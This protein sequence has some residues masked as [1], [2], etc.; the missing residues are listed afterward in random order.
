M[1]ET[2]G[3]PHDER[4]HSHSSPS[5]ATGKDLLSR[6]RVSCR[7][8]RA[9]VIGNV[10][11]P[12][13]VSQEVGGHRR[14][15]SAGPRCPPPSGSFLLR[16]CDSCSS[17]QNLSRRHIEGRQRGPARRQ[18][19]GKAREGL[20]WASVLFSSSCSWSSASG[21]SICL[22]WSNGERTLRLSEARRSRVVKESCARRPVIWLFGVWSQRTPIGAYSSDWITLKE[23]HARRLKNAVR[24]AQPFLRFSKIGV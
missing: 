6:S 22:S 19:C 18:A 15:T 1:E 3:E 8:R 13:N 17:E 7:S 24:R 23:L 12:T 16:V 10:D 20:A 9:H 5:R 21:S 4:R 14:C 11:Q 2:W